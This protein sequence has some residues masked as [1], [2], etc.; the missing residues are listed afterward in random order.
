MRQL[1]A[2]LLGAALLGAAGFA[3]ASV[4]KTN[5]RPGGGS[6]VGSTSSS[7][8]TTGTTPSRK[9]T[10]CHRTGSKTNPGVT[11]TVSENAVPAHMA[12]GDT[13]GPCP[14]RTTT[15]QATTQAEK[16]KP[17]KAKPNKASTSKS[18][19]K[20]KAK[21]KSKADKATHGKAATHGK[22]TTHGKSDTHGKPSK[23]GKPDT[24]GNGNGNG[25]G[26][27]KGK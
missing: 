17:K 8:G 1:M 13:L 18:N 4:V 12:H 23:I 16:P 27:G 22:S 24:H 21:A 19:S 10:I 20:S 9:V 6:T 3:T 15:H 26:H 7:H 5:K 2:V 25:G 14:P 11:I